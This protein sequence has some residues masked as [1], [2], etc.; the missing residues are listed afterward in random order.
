[1]YKVMLSIVASV[2]IL[3]SAVSSSFAQT[4]KEKIIGTWEVVSAVNEADGKKT[5]PFGPNPQGYFVFTSDGHFSTSILRPGLPKFASNNRL[6]GT[7]EENKAVVQ[8]N[9]STFGTYVV[10]SDNSITAHIVG[11]SYPNFS[12]TDQKRGV[13]ITGDQLK[14]SVL[15][16]STGGTAVVTMK[17]AK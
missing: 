1:M 13:E 2:A 4:L 14:W 12:G 6:T 16:A 11:S 3:V 7:P 17:R 10:N 5:E 8:G 9:I 15:T